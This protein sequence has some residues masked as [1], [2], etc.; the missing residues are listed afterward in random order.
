MPARHTAL[1]ASAAHVY[2]LLRRAKPDQR[3]SAA[4][5]ICASAFCRD[6]AYAQTLR[7]AMLRTLIIM[8][9]VLRYMRA[10]RICS[11]NRRH[12]ACRYAM[13]AHAAPCVDYLDAAACLRH[14]AIYSATFCRV[15]FFIYLP[16]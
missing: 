6:V 11:R 12:A 3:D 15:A 16:A 7:Y 2:A 10:A 5:L 8:P 1:R 13:S 9:P 14:A 4:Q